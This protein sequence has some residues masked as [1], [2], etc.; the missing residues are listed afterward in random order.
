MRKLSLILTIIL[1]CNSIIGAAAYE[2]ENMAVL[3]AL[4]I[5]P[6]RI[7]KSN[8]SDAAINADLVYMASKLLSAED[9]QPAKTDNSY[10]EY[11]DFLSGFGIIGIDENLDLEAPVTLDMASK[12]LL[13]VLNGSVKQR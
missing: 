8:L 7:T 1:C 12:V 10:S 2:N 5:L 4:G 9:L 13:S 3:G 6:S 11:N